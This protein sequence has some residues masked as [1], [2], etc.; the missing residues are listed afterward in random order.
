MDDNST[1]S[2]KAELKVQSDFKTLPIINWLPKMHKNSTGARLIVVSRKCSIKT[3][4]MAV[5][6]SF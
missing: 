6:K 1:L 3:L 5:T 4:S 2:K